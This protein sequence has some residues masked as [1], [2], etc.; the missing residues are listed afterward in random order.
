[1]QTRERVTS[2]RPR[3]C[4]PTKVVARSNRS[5]SARGDRFDPTATLGFCREIPVFSRGMRVAHV[6]PVGELD[7]LLENLKGR[8]IMKFI[9]MGCAGLSMAAS[10]LTGCGSAGSPDGTTSDEA[11]AGS[12][13][14]SSGSVA[15]GPASS[16]APANT[17]MKI[18]PPGPTASSREPT[19]A[20]G[21]C[22][23]GEKI[24]ELANDKGICVD[25]CVPDAVMCGTP[26]CAVCDPVGT[27]PNAS[28]NWNSE[29]CEWDCA[30]CDPD[31]PPPEGGCKWDSLHCVWLCI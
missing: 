14:T 7:G 10:V 23:S 30:V 21:E 11:L 17:I 13:T 31:G 20:T 28:C 12:P 19:T 25:R 16:A 9:W 15:K 18:T 8:T 1:M 3:P 6:G 24:C 26:S 5:R 4:R 22:P 29:T 2:G 27:R